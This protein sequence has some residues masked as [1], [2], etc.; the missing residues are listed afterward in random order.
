MD[1]LHDGLLFRIF[2]TLC[3]SAARKDRDK[4]DIINMEYSTGNLAGDWSVR[5]GT[6]DV[7]ATTKHNP[8]SNTREAGT[9]P[10]QCHRGDTN[11]TYTG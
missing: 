4:V 1:G 2:D 3:D 11:R 5:I 10:E 9:T 7:P 6:D 8:K